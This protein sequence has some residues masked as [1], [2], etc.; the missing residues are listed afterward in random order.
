MRYY[1]HLFQGIQLEGS[2][3]HDIIIIKINNNNHRSI[4]VNNYITLLKKIQPKA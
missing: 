1:L 2:S 4:M 3:R